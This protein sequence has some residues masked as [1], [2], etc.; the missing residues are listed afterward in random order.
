MRL[1]HTDKRY[2]LGIK[3][4][5][6]MICIYNTF[7]FLFKCPIYLTYTIRKELAY[8]H[9]SNYIICNPWKTDI[10]K[11]IHCVTLISNK[12]IHRRQGEGPV[13][14]KEKG[15]NKKREKREKYSAHNF[16]RY[17]N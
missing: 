1:I 15:K 8:R 17:L 7:F 5:M 6:L 9:V 11:S 2:K 14:E 10:N 16:T 13:R 4:L 12:T 3:R